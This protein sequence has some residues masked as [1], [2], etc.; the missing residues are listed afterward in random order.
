MAAAENLLKQETSP[1]L[2]QHAGNPVHWRPWGQAALDEAKAANKPLLVSIGYAACHWCHVMAHE[3][4]EDPET[5][6]L[7]N[8]LFVSIKI[9]RE[10]RPDI[11]RIYMAALHAMGEQGGWPLTMFATPD[12]TPFWGGTYFPPEPRWGRPSFRQVLQGVADA[13]HAGADAVTQNSQALKDVLAR[14]ATASIGALPGPAQLDAVAQAYL[15]MTDPEQGGLRGAPKFPNPPIFRFLWQNAFRTGDPAGQDALH[16]MLQRMSQGGIYD[17]LGGGYA[18]YS[19]DAVWLVPHF[20]KM[21]YDNAQILDLLALAHAHRPDPLYAERAAETVGWM[22]RDMTAQRIDGKAAFAASEDADSEGEEGRFYVWTR[23]EV[24]AL[25]GAGAAAFKRAYDVTQ[26]GNWEGHTILR[27][28]TPRGTPAEEAALAQARAILFQAREKRVRPGW[29]DKVLADWN[30]LAIAA[31]AHAA[32]VFAQ[33]AWLERAREAFAFILATMRAPHGGVAHAW[34]LGRVTAAGMIDDQAAMARAALALHEATGDRAYLADALSLVEAAQNSFA[35]GHGGYY[36]TAADAADVPLIR[37]RTAADDVTPAGNGMMAEVFARLY[38]LIGDP[39]WRSV[40]E[41]V[42]TAFSGQPDQLA[43]M[44]TLLAA[45]DLLEE[46]ACVVV[47]GDPPSGALASAALQA[48]D[49]AVVVTRAAEPGS[50]PAGHPAHGKT[51][52]ATG[53]VAYVCRRSV[54]GLPVDD[55]KAL[56][57]ALARRA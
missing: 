52:G 46:A 2:L 34:R 41:A 8:A 5:A 25:L 3:S 35:D 36:T 18:R 30:G 21:L 44:P 24:D 49:P 6:A 13:F 56:R 28:V 38:H 50:L 55:S 9:D 31:L 45:A 33:P 32:A 4:F 57:Q 22:L 48:P 14:Q 26:G 16:L 10:E 23:A 47:A 53:S 40:A 17:H 43:G 1:Y 54:C 42:M 11:D 12:G 7:M 20:E 39:A 19:T 27:R 29:D 37:P 15:R 51:A